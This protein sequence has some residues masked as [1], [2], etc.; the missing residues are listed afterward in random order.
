M[1]VVQK[2]WYLD[3]KRTP[4]ARDALMHGIMG[5]LG[6]GILY[7]AKSSESISLCVLSCVTFKRANQVRDQIIHVSQFFI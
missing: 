5:G 4:C 2:K 7:F 6:I 3:V 1:V